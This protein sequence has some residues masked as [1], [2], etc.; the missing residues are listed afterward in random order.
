MLIER[1]SQ[2]RL[3]KVHTHHT[4]RVINA[5]RRVIEIVRECDTDFAIR[6]DIWI[7]Y[8]HGLNLFIFHGFLVPSSTA[9]IVAHK[10][11]RIS[12]AW[13]NFKAVLTWLGISKWCKLLIALIRWHS[14]NQAASEAR[15]RFW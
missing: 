13:R 10:W 11:G 8:H 1:L 4:F 15:K 3:S 9:R 6:I 2:D 7:S 14:V 12:R 5:V